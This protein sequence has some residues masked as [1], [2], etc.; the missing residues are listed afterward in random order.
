M[1][2]HSD[3]PDARTDL[4]DLFVF[5]NRHD[6]S[7]L[8]LILN[9]NPEASTAT[10]PVDPQ[11]SY[12]LKVDTDGDLEA[13]VALHVM[14]SVGAGRSPAANVYRAT[15]AQARQA[16]A[17]GDLIIANAPVSWDGGVRVTDG[18]GSRFFAGLRSDPWFADVAGVF[19]GFR[20]TGTDT[21]ASRN[22]FGIAIEVPVEWL[23]WTSLG[24]W[25]RSVAVVDGT[26]TTVDQV[27]R[28][29]VSGLLP[30]DEDRLALNRTP[31]AEQLDRLRGP[32]VRLL[33]SFGYDDGDTARLLGDL[34]PDVL[35]SDP[36][37]PAG[38][39][40]GRRLMDDILDLRL[41]MLTRGRVVS[42]G[43]GPHADLLDGFPYLGPPH[44]ATP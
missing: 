31:P 9:V 17:V 3:A 24:V 33:N 39:P 1:A 41:A 23:G 8:V 12:E 4:T 14:F 22:V 7:T 19:D 35:A 38:Y 28:P 16:G 37:R 18:D 40:N 15:G 34:L 11:A 30:T 2:D 42:D 13:D 32:F 6:P 5:P 43:V 10:I 25:A 36:S 44:P 27:G 20:F 21:F 26:A 29:L